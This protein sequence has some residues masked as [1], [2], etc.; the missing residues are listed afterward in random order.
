MK[1]NKEA[2]ARGV[3]LH[4]QEHLRE[5]EKSKA[6]IEKYKRDVIK[7]LRYLEEHSETYTDITKALVVDFKEDLMKKYKI[8]SVNSMLVSVNSYLNFIAKNECRVRQIKVQKMP[9]LDDDKS[10]NIREYKHMLDTA[11]ENGKERL[12]MIIETLGKT[13]LRVSELSDITV[14]QLQTGVIKIHNKG[15][16]RTLAI[17]SELRM[18]LLQYATDHKISSGPIF[19][20]KRG[21]AVNRSNLWK[22]I[23][24]LCEKVG[25]E[26]KK[27]YP[28]NLRHLFARYYYEMEK[29]I[30]GLSEFLGHNSIETTR[31]YTKGN[32]S[33]LVRKLEAMNQHFSNSIA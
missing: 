20:T 15:K 28:H 10:L 27:G 33:D 4:F 12:A 22:E 24:A 11:R 18:K 14:E 9:Y 31:I 26:K 17:T 25:I 29:D 1:N 16:F 8:S 30:V 2:A 19:V 13:G 21:Q 6:T 23:Q 5:D 32:Y 7:F 3:L